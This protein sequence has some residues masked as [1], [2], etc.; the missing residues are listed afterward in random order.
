VVQGELVS[1]LSEGGPLLLPYLVKGAVK[2]VRL[3]CLK[4]RNRVG[5]KKCGN[6]ILP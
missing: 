3:F 1:G 6:E 4:V 2:A 5:I